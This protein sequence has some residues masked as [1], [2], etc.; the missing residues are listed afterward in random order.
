[1]K[2]VLKLILA[3]T[4]SLSLYGVNIEPQQW[5]MLHALKRDAI[6][7]GHGKKDA[8][9][10]VDPKCHR[11][12]EFLEAVLESEKL[13]ETFRYY[14]FVFDMPQVDSHKVVNAVY[15]AEVPLEALKTYMLLRKRISQESDATP[16]SA[17]ERIERIEQTAKTIGIDHTPYL[18]VDSDQQTK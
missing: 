4:L 11:S 2:W 18:I 15:N 7:I 17:R 9:V 5:Q 10:F 14:L 12:A 3:A 1:M 13:Q 8:Y 6:V 16:Q